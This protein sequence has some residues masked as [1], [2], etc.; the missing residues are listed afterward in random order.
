ME[1]KFLLDSNSVIDFL[2][3][4]YPSEGMNLVNSV[5]DDIPNISI[6]SKIEVL[7]YK[8]NEE[9][10]RVLQNFCNDAIMHE[11]NDDIVN[12]TIG[13]RI[14]YKLKTTDA[15]IAATALLYNMILITRNTNDFDKILGL[16]I[17][18]S[19]NL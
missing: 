2:G 19:W 17:I 16:S 13:I 14:E 5:V 6:I 11:L 12:K 1:L 8:T 3:A 10:Y 4:K 18:N 15:I 7:S 9:E